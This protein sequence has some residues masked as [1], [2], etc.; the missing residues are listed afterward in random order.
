MAF[1]VKTF[2]ITAV[3]REIP[4]WIDNLLLSGLHAGDQQSSHFD[5]SRLTPLAKQMLRNIIALIKRSCVL[6]VHKCPAAAA[7]V[8]KPS[9]PDPSILD[10]PQQRLIF[11]AMFAGK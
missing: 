10:H 2:E 4:G 6:I 3:C 8:R 11:H 7:A 1:Q 9:G 5:V